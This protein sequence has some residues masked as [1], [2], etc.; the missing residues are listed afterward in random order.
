MPAFIKTRFLGP[1]NAEWQVRNG[2]FYSNFM[3]WA[4]FQDKAIIMA[5]S[6]VAFCN[7]AFSHN[8]HF[9]KNDFELGLG[10]GGQDTSQHFEGSFG[11]IGAIMPM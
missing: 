2:L 1:P 8:Y 4:F 6:C 5:E 10:G 11:P 3:I 7:T 9:R